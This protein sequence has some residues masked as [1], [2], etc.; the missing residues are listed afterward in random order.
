MRSEIINYF[1][2]ECPGLAGVSRIIAS[3]NHYFIAVKEMELEKGESM[4]FLKEFVNNK[5]V[6]LR[7]GVS[8][9]L[10]YL[11][12]LNKRKIPVEKGIELSK[13]YHRNPREL[14]R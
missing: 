7:W 5:N 12:E 8:N 3:A 4:T 2:E 10:N 1:Q 6:S 11:D 13:T 9:A 14:A